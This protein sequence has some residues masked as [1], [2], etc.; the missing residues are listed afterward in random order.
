[1]G[2]W[3]TGSFENDDALD[4]LAEWSDAKE[5][6][7]DEDEPGRF[8]YV[9]GAL[10]VAV[11]E[12]GYLDSDAGACALAAAE[13]VAAANGKPDP[14]LKKNDGDVAALVTWAR[15]KHADDLRNPQAKQLALQ[16]VDRVLAD[17]SE[18]AELWSESEEAENW[19]KAVDGLRARLA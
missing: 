10:A 11:D 14:S 12:K 15:S 9:I 3:G 5:G 4:W 8:A 6:P 13:A 19:R 16:A 17:E 7:G 2:A 18:L 1:M